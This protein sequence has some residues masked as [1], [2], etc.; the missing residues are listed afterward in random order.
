MAI[1]LTVSPDL[2]SILRIGAFA[3]DITRVLDM[4]SA[5]YAPFAGG[6]ETCRWVI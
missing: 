1:E 5:R 3:C 4:T 2:A 6:V